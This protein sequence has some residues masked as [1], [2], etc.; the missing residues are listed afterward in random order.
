MFYTLFFHT[1]Y[2][3]SGMC[4]KSGMCFYIKSISQFKLGAFDVLNCNIQLI[5]TI[6]DS[7]AV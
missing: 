6:L 5:A 3:K 7:I 2:E 1:R 4:S